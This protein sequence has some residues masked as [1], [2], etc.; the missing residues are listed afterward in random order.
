MQD[1]D[2]FD[3][4]GMREDSES[5]IETVDAEFDLDED[6][7]GLFADIDNDEEMTLDEEAEE[8]LAGYESTAEDYLTEGPLAVHKK[9][10][11]DPHPTKERL[12]DIMRR[13]HTGDRD[14]V[15]QAQTDM[16]GI[17]D[18]YI[19][20]LIRTKYHN[21]MERHLADMICHGYEGVIAGM[22]TFDPEKGMPSTWFSRYIN[23]E[24]QRYLNSQV[25]H[26][27]P[28]Y[29]A[30][31]KKVY[32]C[33]EAKKEKNI[34]FTLKDIYI[35]TGVPVKTIE[36]CMSIRNIQV[37]SISTTV[38]DLDIPTDYGDPERH[39]EQ[40]EAS[41]TIMGLVL[42]KSSSTGEIIASVL[43]Q[44]EQQCLIL[45]YGLD[46]HEQRSLV[47]I[48]EITGIPKYRISKVIATALKKM[49]EEMGKDK[50]R[51][52]CRRIRERV[53][54]ENRMSGA[55]LSVEECESDQEAVQ[56]YY[57]MGLVTEAII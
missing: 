1:F 5:E 32:A 47:E 12:L 6:Y 39:A 36:R 26:S 46:G 28:H 7:G 11:H 2:N 52:L 24:I 40:K 27:T 25:N 4:F 53:E 16:L 42:G 45:Y 9:L 50:R 55:L 18:P 38:K 29:V 43:D 48:E 41:E 49:R 35:E 3:L 19:L 37:G 34:P 54:T 21:Y 23:H 44:D 15:D 33:I 10:K 31:Q 30:A 8:E 13:Y 57:E 17:L 20:S 22:K 14:L 51:R 56:K